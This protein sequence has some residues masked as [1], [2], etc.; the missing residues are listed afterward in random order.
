M[1]ITSTANP[2]V[3]A[4]RKLVRRHGRARAGDAFLVEGPQAV[5]EA[6]PFLQQLFA[7]AEAAEAHADLIAAAQ[8]TGA[9]VLTVADDVLDELAGT[10]TTQGLV[11]VATVAAQSLEGV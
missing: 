4:A 1:L 3:K 5:R 10:V 11:G 9:Q 2:A 6:G 8:Q 7:T